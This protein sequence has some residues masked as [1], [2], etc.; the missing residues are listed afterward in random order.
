MKSS[1]KPGD[2][3]P[4]TG[5]KTPASGK[6][7]VQARL[8]FKTLGGSEPPLTPT[9]E[10]SNAALTNTLTPVAANRKRKQNTLKDD[11]V[12]A[13]KFNRCEPK[14]HDDIILETSEAMELS[15]ETPIVIYDGADSKT[16]LNRS[17]ESKE[18]VCI[19][20]DDD[21]DDDDSADE[22][23]IVDNQ[24]E[25]VE[26]V[27]ST[28]ST[29][30]AKQSLEFDD[31]KPEPRKSKRNDLI[32]IKLPMSKKAKV[33]AKKAKKQKK[34]DPNAQTDNEAQAEEA[35]TVDDVDVDMGIEDQTD[36][37][38][39][40]SVNECVS[41]EE[42]DVK[43]S[44]NALNDSILSNASEQSLTPAKHPLTPRQLQKRIESEKKKLEKDQAK[45]D[46]EQ[47]KKR[48]REEKG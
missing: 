42:D 15:N 30:K 25:I 18:N 10:T 46:R 13:P 2:V 48:E 7:L 32:K 39:T 40:S 23:K 3:P 5:S 37:V 35:D 45:L 34:V 6:K 14:T 11:G 27:E 22:S 28:K 29:S 44:E 17:S 19:S 26:K 36:D 16:A 41:I 47:Q 31:N 9:N 21:D 8:P 12:R 20:D 38:N 1:P 4:S 43:P 33:A 24:N